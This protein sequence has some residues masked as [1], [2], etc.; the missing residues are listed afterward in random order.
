MLKAQLMRGNGR[1]KCATGM[2]GWRAPHSDDVQAGIELVAV[3]LQGV[4]QVIVQP[5]EVIDEYF[6]QTRHNCMAKTRALLQSAGAAITC[7]VL[8][9]HS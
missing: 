2:D 9:L 7:R 3:C 8:R 6:L 1:V 5:V 4:P